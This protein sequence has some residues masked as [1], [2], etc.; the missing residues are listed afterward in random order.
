[1]SNALNIIILPLARWDGPYSSTALSLALELSKRHKVFYIDNPFTYK[2]ILKKFNSKQIQKRRKAFFSKRNMYLKVENAPQ[3]FTAVFVKPVLPIN[4]L[5]SGKLYDYLLKVNDKV[6][7]TALKKIIKDYQLESYVFINSYNPFYGLSFPKKYK[8][9]LTVYHCVDNIEESK[10]VAKHGKTLEIA[11]AKK[12]SIILTTSTALTTKFEQLGCKVHFIPNAADITL[13]SKSL[14][15]VLPRPKELPENKKIIGYFGN[16]C[17]RIDYDIIKAL[18]KSNPDKLICLVG[19]VRKEAQ[20]AGIAEIKN[21][22]LPGKK[23]LEE[24]PAYL[25]YFDVCIIPF[26][27]NKLTESIYPLKINEYLAGGKP[28]VSTNFS[29]DISSFSPVIYLANETGEFVLKVSRAM[30]ENSASKVEAGVK[31]SE[32]N[33]WAKRALQ[34]EKILINE[35][36]EEIA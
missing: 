11:A 7:S 9:A 28:V 30:Q 29:V 13:F 3:N 5:P 17:H 2:D 36:K 26:K 32:N 4:F 27:K 10:Y 8:P 18:A 35:M 6:I 16:I 23:K 15:E 21:I 22:I 19:P 1:M 20:I 31:F 25:K 33:S 12:A 34:V 24:L 14:S